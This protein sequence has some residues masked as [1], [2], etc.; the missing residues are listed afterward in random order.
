VGDAGG[1]VKIKNTFGKV[2][3][4]KS[5]VGEKTFDGAENAVHGIVGAW[6][7]GQGGGGGG[8]G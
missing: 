8:D 4:Q 5:V 6:G 7:M 1:V 3:G 2:M